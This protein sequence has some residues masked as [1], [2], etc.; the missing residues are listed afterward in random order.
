MGTTLNMKLLLTT[1][2]CLVSVHVRAKYFLVETGEK[3]VGE[4]GGAGQGYESGSDYSDD[5]SEGSTSPPDEDSKKSDGGSESS[6][7]DSESSGGDAVK[8]PSGGDP[9]NSGGDSDESDGGIMGL[10][11]NLIPKTFDDAY[12]MASNIFPALK[13][14]KVKESLFKLYENKRPIFEDM[15]EVLEKLVPTLKPIFEAVV[16]EK[17]ISEKDTLKYKKEFHTH[18]GPILK[19]LADAANEVL[20]GLEVIAEGSV[21]D[22][23]KQMSFLDGEIKQLVEDS[24]HWGNKLLKSFIKIVKTDDA[25]KKESEQ[26]AQKEN[27]EENGS[28]YG[29]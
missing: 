18:A 16:N 11:A 24:L 1:T 2:L 8:A 17:E 13:D 6:G 21:D 29:F 10:I 5:A 20:P 14:A 28:D 26:S 12:D 7:D 19:K 27:K 22:L 4:N 25:G 23:M 15:P 9:E 3:G